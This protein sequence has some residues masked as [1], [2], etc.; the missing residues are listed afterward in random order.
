MSQTKYV[1]VLL[2]I[3]L[4]STL[5]NGLP[6]ADCKEIDAKVEVVKSPATGKNMLKITVSDK[7]DFVVRVLDPEKKITELKKMEVH[8]LIEGEYVVVIHGRGREGGGRCPF[9]KAI[10]IER[11]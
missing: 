7:I 10:Q 1:V 2:L 3:M 9:T 8:N 11:Q 6:K 4:Q 5:S